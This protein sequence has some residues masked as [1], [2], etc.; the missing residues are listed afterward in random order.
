MSCYF[1][2]VLLPLG[3]GFT[4]GECYVIYIYIYSLFHTYK[5]YNVYFF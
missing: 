4:C 5:V 2:F 3:H 1:Y